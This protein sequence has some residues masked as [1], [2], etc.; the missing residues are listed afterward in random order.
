MGNLSAP[1]GFSLEGISQ[2]DLVA[3]SGLLFAAGIVVFSGSLYLLVLTGRR[4]LGA[5]TPLGGL[6]MLAGWIVL[7]WGAGRQA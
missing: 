6:L 1:E 3:K 7:A 4:W 2:P 5:V